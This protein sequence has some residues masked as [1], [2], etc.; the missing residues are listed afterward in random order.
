ML[1]F[2]S[3]IICLLIQERVLRRF[4]EAVPALLASHAKPFDTSC[5]P[6]WSCFLKHFLRKGEN[7]IIPT[8]IKPK[9]HWIFNMSVYVG[10]FHLSGGVIEAYPPSDSVTCLTVDLL[11]E[12]G[13]EVRMLS[14][15]DQLHGPGV[16][17]VSGCSVP[18]SSVCPKVLYSI[19]MRI[20]KACQERHIL[21]HFSL[22]LVTFLEPGILEQEVRDPH[23]DQ[24]YSVQL[25]LNT[26]Y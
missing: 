25:V 20:G 6:T 15:G 9:Y 22:D 2:Q 23:S 3:I 26:E 5:Y 19:C 8:G 12:P 1:V 18:Q 7:L 24:T 13:G 16:L 4:L 21:G 14:C 10:F 11:V 17:Q